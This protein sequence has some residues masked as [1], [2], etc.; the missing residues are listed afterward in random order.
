MIIINLM[1]IFVQAMIK[2]RIPHYAI[3]MVETSP[4]WI[5]R[6]STF[7]EYQLQHMIN[8]YPVFYKNVINPLNTQNEIYTLT[9]QLMTMKI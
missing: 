4:E 5:E 2:Q 6:F 8:F 7:N 9:N 3:N 1:D